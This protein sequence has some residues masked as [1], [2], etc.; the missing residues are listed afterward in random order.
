[1]I[2]IA[3]IAA[4]YGLHPNTIR[5]QLKQ[6]YC[7][8]PRKIAD[9]VSSNPAYACWENM[10]QRCTNP[11]ASKYHMYG[12]VGITVYPEW[13][14]DFRKFIAYIGER[15]SKLHSIDR[16]DGTKGYEPGNVRWADAVQQ[17]IN[18]PN[19]FYIEK[20]RNKYRFKFNNKRYSFPTLEEAMQAKAFL[21][22][23]YH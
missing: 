13:K 6:G 16:I 12:G 2:N 7:K 20:H 19:S 1:M 15:P 21:Q 5:N 10:V 22:E 9:G 4:T 23:D 14:S 17:S 18:K 8:W 11:K 3:Q